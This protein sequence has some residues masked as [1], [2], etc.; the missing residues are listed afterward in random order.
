MTSLESHRGHKKENR[1]HMLIIQA[2]DN[3]GCVW[4]LLMM[5]A[6]ITSLT[7]FGGVCLAVLAAVSIIV[8][9]M[10]SVAVPN[11]MTELLTTSG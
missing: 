10:V 9:Y 4:G 11:H 7:L 8:L 1:D 5:C 6:Y 2:A 3:R